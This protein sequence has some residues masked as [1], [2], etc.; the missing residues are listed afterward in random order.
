MHLLDHERVASEVFRIASSAGAI[1][2]LG[3][4]ERNPDSA[5]ERMAKEM[6]ERLRQRGFEPRRGERQNSKL[7]ESC[8]RRGAIILEPVCIAKWNVS[9]SPQQSLDS[10][11]RLSSLGG[12]QVP[13]TT[14]AEILWELSVWAEEMFG[15]LDEECESEESYV[16]KPFSVPSSHT[17]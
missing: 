12:I 6:N 16:L 4:V 11:R 3:R 14:R 17:V 7:L 2:M 15:G 1:L 5:R 10:W 8:R 9:T 13:S